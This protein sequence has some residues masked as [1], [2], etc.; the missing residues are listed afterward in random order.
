MG[1]RVAAPF[2]PQNFLS[3]REAAERRYFLLF[4]PFPPLSFSALL[5]QEKEES[6]G[7]DPVVFKALFLQ[8]P[9]LWL[10]ADLLPPSALLVKP[11]YPSV[12]TMSILSSSM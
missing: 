12:S 8:R 5:L 3:Y 1:W 11:S 6:V 4:Q 7:L 10:A 9:Q 2:H